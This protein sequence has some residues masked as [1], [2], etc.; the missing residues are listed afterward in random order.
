M[1]VKEIVKVYRLIGGNKLA[2][3]GRYH[4]HDI[5]D[6]EIH[7]FLEGKGQILLNHSR[8]D[9]EGNRLILAKPKVFH[10]ILPEKVQKPITYYAIRFEPN[11]N[12]NEIISLM[13]NSSPSLTFASREH[14]MIED[15]YRLTKEN[16]KQKKKAAEFLFLSLLYRWYRKEGPNTNSFKEEFGDPKGYI[17]KTVSIMEKSI[18]EKLNIEEL[19]DNLGLSK[20]HYIR[21]FHQALGITPFQYFTRLRIEAASS[22]L[23]ETNLPIQYVSDHFGFENPFHF[24]RTFKKCTGFSPTE[25]RKTYVMQSNTGNI[26]SQNHT[27]TLVSLGNYDETVQGPLTARS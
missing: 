25:Y 16:E 6:Y 11:K 4:S 1:Y 12:D 26:E 2:W 10:S 19:A 7:L 20:E 3:H 24:S 23:T 13:E 8:Y 9:I 17:N 14:F 15:L 27:N 18:K 21:I 22:Y 5:T